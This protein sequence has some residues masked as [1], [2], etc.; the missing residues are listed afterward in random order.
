MPGLLYKSGKYK[1]Y[2]PGARHR[3]QALDKT[4]GGASAAAGGSLIGPGN[5][6]NAMD[7]FGAMF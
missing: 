1:E 2:V 5:Y 4:Y 3:L 6:E 7:P